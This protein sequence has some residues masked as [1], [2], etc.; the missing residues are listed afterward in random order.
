MYRK[1]KNEK[2]SKFLP[3]TWTGISSFGVE[4]PIHY[5]TNSFSVSKASKYYKKSLDQGKIY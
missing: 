4:A 5:T 3:G 1:N 2:K